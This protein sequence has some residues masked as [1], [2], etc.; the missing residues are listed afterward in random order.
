MERKATLGRKKAREKK[1]NW[2][3]MK[4]KV[5]EG[6]KEREY[7]GGEGRKSRKEKA[8][9]KRWSDKKREG[10]KGGKGMKGGNLRTKRELES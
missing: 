7:I 4:S 1:G 8:I 6:E 9:G 5:M 2:K 3:E 10:V